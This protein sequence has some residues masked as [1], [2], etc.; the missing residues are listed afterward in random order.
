MKIISD[1]LTFKGS[2]SFDWCDHR[3]Y[4]MLCTRTL[5]EYVDIPA[6]VT[7]IWIVLSDKPMAESYRVVPP[8]FGVGRHG[9]FSIDYTDE[10]L[11]YALRR[12]LYKAMTEDFKGKAVYGRIE[13]I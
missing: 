10:R 1:E 2:L 9:I 3:G 5:D 8:K 11:Y 7:K 6:S 13:Y 12:W 4:R